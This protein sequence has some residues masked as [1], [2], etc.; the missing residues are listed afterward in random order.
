MKKYFI[1]SNLSE[2]V[3]F[4]RE[5]A[6][7]H[8]PFVLNIHEFRYFDIRNIPYVTIGHFVGSR[9]KRELF[10]N[11]L[12]FLRRFINEMDMHNISESKKI[13]DSDIK[14]F[15]II[16]YGIFCSFHNVFQFANCIHLMRRNCECEIVIPL[17]QEDKRSAEIC[18]PGLEDV[19]YNN[20][21]AFKV[22][23]D[24]FAD[25]T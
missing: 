4:S 1:V 21:G 22:V 18:W 16:G 25:T 23:S 3:L 12:D 5:Y 6:G 11:F 14:L 10:K 9:Q 19:F 8:I 7:T 17:S 13:F 2:C 20:D 15:S 24:Y